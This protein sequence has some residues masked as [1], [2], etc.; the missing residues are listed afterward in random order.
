MVD[1]KQIEVDKV[2]NDVDDI[3]IFENKIVIKDK[4]GKYYRFDLNKIGILEIDEA[5]VLF[6]KEMPTFTCRKNSCTCWKI[7][8]DIICRKNKSD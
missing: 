2:I 8:P 1:E 5:Y 3:T 7:G 4:K 6:S